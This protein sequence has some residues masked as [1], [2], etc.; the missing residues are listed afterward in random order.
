MNNGLCGLC[1]QLTGHPM[2]QADTWRM[3]RRR[4]VATGVT[5]P[6]GNHTF[7]APDITTYLANGG[8]LEHAQVMAG[9]ENPRTTKLYD[10][11]KDR[12]TQD[13]VERIRL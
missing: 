9:H 10:R 6:I 1:L 3:M 4:A 12:L 5:T 7:R 2:A 8:A 13:K 11:T